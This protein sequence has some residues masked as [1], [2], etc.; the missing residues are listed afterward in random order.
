MVVVN[1]SIELPNTWESL[2]GSRARPCSK[3]SNTGYLVAVRRCCYALSRDLA[4]YKQAL[5]RIK[6]EELFYFKINL[7]VL[8]AENKSE[9]NGQVI[10]YDEHAV[11]DQIAALPFPLTTAQRAQFRGNSGR[12]ALRCSHE[13][14]F[15]RRC[16][17]WEDC[18]C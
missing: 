8:K 2:A 11:A 14:S 18:Y 6:F 3:R 1:V 16:G 9:T 5:R 10:A 12:Y 4:D 7:Q 13:P 15:A 17:L